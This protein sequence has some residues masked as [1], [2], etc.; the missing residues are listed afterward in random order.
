MKFTTTLTAASLAAVAAA[1]K[2]AFSFAVLR[3]NG[4]GFLTEGLVDPIV[5]PGAQASH[6]HGV[7]GGSNFGTTV[8]GD[9]LL[10]SKCTTAKIKNDKSNYWTNHLFFQDPNDQSSFEKVDLFYMNVYYFFE[11]GDQDIEPFPPGLKMLSGNTTTRSPPAVGGKIN[12]DASQGP[13][14]P[15]Q[16]T[17]PRSS[18]DPPSY[19]A[20]SD[21]SMAG[22]QDPQNQGAGAGLPLY[23]CDGYASPLR[24]DIHFPSCYNPKVGLDDYE[25]NM[26][27]PT[28]N[29]GR[30]SCPEG[31]IRVPH[32][33]YE[34]Y[35]QTDA[36]NGRWTPDGKT[37]PFLLSNGDPTGYSSHGDFL[38][39]WDEETLRTIINTCDAGTTG[40]DKCPNI[41][42]GLND[43]QDCKI[44]APL[45]KVLASSTKFNSLP[46]NNKVTGWGHGGVTGGSVEST[47]ASSS[48]AYDAGAASPTPSSGGGAFIEKSSSTNSPAETPAVSAA[49]AP[50]NN[51]NVE[52]VWD[53]VTVTETTTIGAEPTPAPAKRRSARHSHG[54]AARHGGFA[55]RR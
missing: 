31:Y 38:A 8:E 29:G 15:V 7:M 13:I 54:H 45:G 32:L 30:M 41:P 12:L 14:N 6:Y 10:D 2:D 3:F 55:G 51:P 52:V 47:P 40:M 11:P 20:D 33:F 4:E 25:N 53:Y 42:G 28:N 1:G 22:I 35:W 24:Q 46:G 36:F 50:E 17:C 16:W 18:Y 26:A 9:Q 21:G 49:A 43:V 27:W 44:P 48:S 5:N 39:G 37:Q 34:V 19:P 23:P